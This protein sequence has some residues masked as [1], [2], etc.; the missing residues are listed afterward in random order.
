MACRD[1]PHPHTGERI[2]ELLQKIFNDH[3]LSLSNVIRFTTDKGANV[4][5]GLQPFRV[6]QNV[7][8]VASLDDVDELGGLLVPDSTSSE[9]QRF[10]EIE[11]DI[12]EDDEESA[13]EEDDDEEIEV[14]HSATGLSA[15]DRP[16]TATSAPSEEEEF[17]LME[18]AYQQA[19]PKRLTCVAHALNLIFHKILDDDSNA[20]GGTRKTILKFLKKINSSGVANQ[21]LKRLA[22]KKLLKVAKTRWGSYYY[23]LRRLLELE[24]EIIAV[25]REK[26]WGID[27]EFS[28]IKKFV[29]L[30]S[31]LAAATTFLEG[32]QYPTAASV[33]P[34]ILSLQDHFHEMKTK[35]PSLVG[36]C[37]QF[38]VEITKRFNYFLDVKDDNFD[39]TLL[40]CCMLNPQRSLEL[41][42]ELYNEGVRRLLGFL[43]SEIEAGLFHLKEPKESERLEDTQPV[44]NCD[45]QVEQGKI[46]HYIFLFLISINLKLF[47]TFFLKE[48]N[49]SRGEDLLYLLHLHPKI[50]QP[51][52][53]NSN[54]K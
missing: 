54:K 48:T 43:K 24:P 14:N 5:K 52:R 36:I 15:M 13:E 7:P 29:A 6:I 9:S 4:V 28:D 41:S 3:S 35:E 34:S 20:I 45:P 11:L 21:E 47:T 17:D 39:Q 50:S 38:Q 12:V 42:S 49:C 23:V 27:F 53:R 40:M 18:E 8:T 25:C 44:P 33:I 19:F 22:G 26:L 46:Y 10:V 16:T 31:P 37:N 30:M 32:D 51:L 2:K 1:F